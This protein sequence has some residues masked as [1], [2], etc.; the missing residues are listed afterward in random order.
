MFWKCDYCS[1][2]WKTR[3]WPGAPVV[4]DEASPEG[5]A[6]AFA[7]C[8]RPGPHGSPIIESWNG[9]SFIVRGSESGERLRVTVELLVEARRAEALR[10]RE[11]F[12]NDQL[13]NQT[14]NAALYFARVETLREALRFYAERRNYLPAAG[15]GDSYDAMVARDS[16]DDGGPG[17]RARAA[18]KEPP[19][20][21]DRRGRSGHER[22]HDGAV[23]AAGD[24]LLRV[25][26][27]GGVL[28]RAVVA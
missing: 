4:R 15:T 17:A 23:G 12:L 9:A 7:A 13:E 22:Q 25:V 2:C 21:S 1:R 8:L 26:W 6:R 20:T 19:G 18:L 27:W 11:E 3:A 16:Y 10:S 24:V 14:A 28:E 5:M